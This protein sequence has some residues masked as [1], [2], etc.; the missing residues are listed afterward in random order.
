SPA[1]VEQVAR[2]AAEVFDSL[3]NTEGV[4]SLALAIASIGASVTA[5]TAFN[6]ELQGKGKKEHPAKPTAARRSWPRWSSTGYS[7]TWSARTSSVCGIVRPSAFAVLRL[8]TSSNFV[9]RS[10]GRSA[11]LA[12]LRILS[13]NDAARRKLSTTFTA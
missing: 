10:T 7:T 3:S 11:G 6:P 9:G 1:S 5:T 13:T 12:P 4:G 2:T 8:I